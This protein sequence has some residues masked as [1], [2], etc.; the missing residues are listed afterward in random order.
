M[1]RRNDGLSFAPEKRKHP[2]GWLILAALVVLIALAAVINT[3]NNRHVT[4][5]RQS[6]TDVDL[7]KALEKFSILHVSDLH[8][9]RFGAG[10]SGFAD[11]IKGLKYQAVCITGD[12]VG[13]NGDYQPFLELLAALPG[14]IPVYFIAGDEDPAP[15]YTRAHGADSVLAEFIT[16]AE[17]MGAIYLDTPQKLTV[18][19]EEIWF[20]PESLY[21]L[22]VPSSIATLTAR[23]EEILAGADAYSPDNGAV[24]RALDYQLETLNASV[25]ARAQ[26]AGHTQV[27][28]SHHPLTANMLR[29]L[30]EWSDADNAG[31]FREVTLILAGHYNGGQWRLPIL[32]ALRAPASSG[33]GNDGWLPDDAQVTGLTLSLGVAQYVSPGLGVASIY[34]GMPFRL[35]NAPAVTL[36]TLTQK[37]H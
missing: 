29:T 1:K 15:I 4:V 17:D 34:K 5:V 2:F 23:R 33:L 16:V 21:S 19:K 9:A 13:A 32:G 11:V 8:G 37:I 30:Q 6:V 14:D 3:A 36:I 12:V 27:L 28:L 25:E 24:L 35:M 22:D 31:L 26:M 20:C 18:G 7:P 10:Q